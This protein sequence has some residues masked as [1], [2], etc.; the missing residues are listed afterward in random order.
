MMFTYS[1]D[2]LTDGSEKSGS[3]TL[4]LSVYK[5]AYKPSSID[6]NTLNDDC[7]QARYAISGL[8]DITCRAAADQRFKLH[9]VRAV[10]VSSRWGFQTLPGLMHVL[11]AAG[12][13]ELTV[14][15]AWQRKTEQLIHTVCPATHPAVRICQVPIDA[16]EK[17]EQ[18]WK[19]YEDPFLLVHA[20]S[21][22]AKDGM[23]VIYLYTLKRLAGGSS[24]LLLVPPGCSSVSLEHLPVATTAE[25]TELQLE[26]V[27][28]IR[29]RNL[30]E[31]LLQND[32]Q[33]VDSWYDVKPVSKLDPGLLV[34]AQLQS[35]SWNQVAPEH[36]PWLSSSCIPTE[37]RRLASG[38]TLTLR[39][40]DA[41]IEL[42][43]V[44]RLEGIKNSSTTRTERH[45]WPDQLQDFLEHTRADDEN[46]IDIGDVVDDDSVNDSGEATGLLVLGTGCASPSPYRGSSGYV[47]MLPSENDKL[48]MAVAFEVGEGF[49]TQW[50]RY[51]KGKSLNVI[52]LIWISHAHWDHYGGLVNLL[53]HMKEER[54]GS[55]VPSVLAYSRKRIRAE[56]DDPPHVIAPRKVLRYLDFSFADPCIYFRGCHH[57]KSSRTCLVSRA[58][59]RPDDNFSPIVFWE[60]VPVE[61]SC[62]EAHGFV[63]GWRATVSEELRIMCFSGD[64]LPCRKLVIACRQLMSRFGKKQLDFLIHEAT[65]D[66]EECEMSRTKKHSTVDEA[67]QIA[68]E[69][70]AFRTL[71]T[72]FSQRYDTFP[73]FEPKMK[74]RIGVALDG[75]FVGL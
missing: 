65:F 43:V 60:D 29:L 42:L 56:E 21:T 14:V 64:T 68:R 37:P 33:H 27:A 1:V 24:S 49:V 34:R 15:T 30:D 66:Q 19:V 67:V 25:E 71:L 75:M 69:T 36:F 11:R 59:V 48:T 70:C 35:R 23:A 6:E 44:D 2:V 8:G 74:M 61:H 41:G 51:A 47:W 58:L 55:P 13:P 32:R 16:S 20:S 57:E 4:F 5:H 53:V 62:R 50:G 52:K 10:F 7:L 9:P 63:M 40:V 39:P 12:R 18:W 26:I 31:S 28:R 38:A 54:T 46:E 3:P 73:R 17:K 72:H 22:L 45:Q